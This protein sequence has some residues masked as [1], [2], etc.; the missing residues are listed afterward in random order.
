MTLEIKM[1]EYRAGLQRRFNHASSQ[2]ERI[3]EDFRK[4]PLED[5]L[6]ERYVSE[7]AHGYPTIEIIEVDKRFLFGIRVA[8]EALK[9][10]LRDLDS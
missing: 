7:D 4:C 2:F 9:V 1:P 10:E 6:P 5:S 8:R 3:A